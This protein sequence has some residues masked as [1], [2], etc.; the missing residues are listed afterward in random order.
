MFLQ[1]KLLSEQLDSA[2][3]AR[4]ESID[5]CEESNGSNKNY[6]VLEAEFGGAVKKMFELIMD[7]LKKLCSLGNGCAVSGESLGNITSWEH[8]FKLFVSN[9]NVEELCDKILK[10]IFCAVSLSYPFSGM[11]HICVHLFLVSLSSDL[12]CLHRKNC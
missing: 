6:S 9:L 8:L 4:N 2:I 10:T 12:M 11:S 3:K 1:G 7:V 5:T